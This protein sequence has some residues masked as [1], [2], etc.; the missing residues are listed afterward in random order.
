MWTI[1]VVA[2]VVEVGIGIGYFVTRTER[3]MNLESTHS[4]LVDINN[5]PG[6]SPISRHEVSLLCLSRLLPQLLAY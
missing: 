5:H 4:L 6:R 2:V 3:T 1:V